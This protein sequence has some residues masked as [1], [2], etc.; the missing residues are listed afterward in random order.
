[1]ENKTISMIKSRVSCRAYSEKKVPL[2]K[3]LQVAEAGKMAPSG[4]NRQI[5][6]ILV[7]RKKSVVEKLRKLAVELGGKD[8][9]Y[10]ASTLILVYGPRED[11]FT[12]LDG[13]CVLENMFIAATA[14]KI[15]SCWIHRTDDVLSSPKGLKIKKQ[16]GIPEDA[17]VVGTCILGY[18]KDPASLA[19]K[20]RKADFVKVI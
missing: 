4:M 1:M 2:S 10:G 19:V 7:L 12:A 15:N 6:N 17:R 9:Y 11:K 5:V 14:L 13:A 3:A 20:E 16:L 8:P 18:A